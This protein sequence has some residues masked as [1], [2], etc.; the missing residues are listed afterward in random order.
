MGLTVANMRIID[1]AGSVTPDDLGVHPGRD[2]FIALSGTVA[3]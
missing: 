2:W 3:L 1:L